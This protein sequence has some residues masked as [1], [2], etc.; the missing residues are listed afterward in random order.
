[1]ILFYQP[2][3]LLLPRPGP[4]GRPLAH[5]GPKQGSK[6]APRLLLLTGSLTAKPARQQTGWLLH[7]H[8]LE[9]ASKR[10]KLT[11]S[12]IFARFSFVVI[13]SWLPLPPCPAAPAHQAAAAGRVR[14]RSEQAS[15]SSRPRATH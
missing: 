7:V 1:V 8:V 13:W 12:R 4:R 10:T 14:A 11:A 3:F 15:G 9:E 2:S 6:G 5:Q